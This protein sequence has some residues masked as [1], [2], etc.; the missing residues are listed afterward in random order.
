[1]ATS[2]I[3]GLLASSSD[4]NQILVCE[5]DEN[6]AE[7]IFQNA[8]DF[9]EELATCPDCG[10]KSVDIRIQDRFSIHELMDKF[11]GRNLPS[12]Y[13]TAEINKN[14]YLVDLED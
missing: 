12:K 3:G 2:L 11:H 14:L 13:C 1:M 7:I 4:I 6:K 5:P 10:N 9:T 8:G